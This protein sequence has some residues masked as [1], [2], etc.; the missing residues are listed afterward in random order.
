M[1]EIR[2]GERREGRKE[3]HRSRTFP[4][5]IRLFNPPAAHVS[6]LTCLRFYTC[7][8]PEGSVGM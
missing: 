6:V 8:D 5:I 4:E 2:K 7:E 1:G 3:G